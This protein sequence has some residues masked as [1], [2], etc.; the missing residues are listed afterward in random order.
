MRRAVKINYQ[1]KFFLAET[2]FT[3]EN[4]LV[5]AQ[6]IFEQLMVENGIEADTHITLY[7]QYATADESLD[8][9]SIN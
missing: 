6:W 4:S 7:S 5:Y 3:E 2:R 9:K 1:N 8:L